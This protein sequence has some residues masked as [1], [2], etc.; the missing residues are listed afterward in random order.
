MDRKKTIGRN[1][2]LG[3]SNRPKD[4]MLQDIDASES[5]VAGVSPLPSSPGSPDDPDGI[6]YH[7]QDDDNDSDLDLNEISTSVENFH[8]Q[9][10][11]LNSISTSTEHLAR[12]P[13][14]SPEEQ[15]KRQILQCL[16]LEA[17]ILFH[18]IFIGM[19]LSVATGPAFV[20]LLTAI[21]FHQTFEGL[22]LGARIAAVR[23]PARSIR[24]WLMVLAFGLTTPLGQ[25]AGLALHELYDP[26][27]AAGLVI[28]GFMNA[29]SSGL[30]LFAGLVQLL[31]GDFLSKES[32]NVL[33]GARRVKAYLTVVGGAALMAAVGAF[34]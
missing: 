7:D 9:P 26:R 13:A 29:V 28:V 19:A 5:L 1:G 25:A 32:Y 22:A 30:L 14:L 33:H 18:S 8:P 23:Y 12:K 27:S 4:I 2:R 6:K 10:D 15:Q 20:A 17:G 21:S 24:P 11:P 34:A 3:L 31:A 16:L